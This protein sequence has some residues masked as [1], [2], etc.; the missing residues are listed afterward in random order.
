MFLATHATVGAIVGR[1]APDP[2]SAFFLAFASHFLLDIIPHGDADLYKD[3][4]RGNKVRLA[5]SYTMIDAI[6]TAYVVVAIAQARLF[7]S[8]LNVAAGVVGGLLPDLLVGIFEVTKTRWLVKFHAVH[9][10]FHNMF[11]NKYRDV[12][13][14]TGVAYQLV[15]LIFLQ[16]RI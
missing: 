10:F 12:S 16:T 13:F 14:M 7:D 8:G 2:I 9:F 15:I 3:Y 5:L 6:V 4:K 1:A 11:V